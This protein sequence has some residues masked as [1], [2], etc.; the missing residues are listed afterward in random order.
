ME[1]RLTLKISKTDAA[2]RQLETAIRLWFFSQDPVSTHTLAAAANQIL[3][4]IG[5]KRNS[6]SMLRNLQCVRPEYETKVREAV[7]R[8]ENFFKHADKDPDGL[9][10]FNPDATQMYLLDSVLTYQNL[11]QEVT[12]IF[13]AFKIW[14]FIKFPELMDAEVQE[15]MKQMQNGN[16]IDIGQMPKADFFT[17]FISSN[18]KQGMNI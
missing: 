3:H 13:G 15:K 10:D 7:S 16:Q 2:K 4:D 9:L 6:P 18:L 11:T 8:Y 12:S 14:M 5:K 1:K 17:S